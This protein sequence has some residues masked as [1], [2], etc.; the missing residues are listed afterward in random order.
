MGEE[1][2]KRRVEKGRTLGGMVGSGVVSSKEGDSNGMWNALGGGKEKSNGEGHGQETWKGVKLT[3]P[4]DP[5]LAARAAAESGS[6]NFTFTATDDPDEELPPPLTDQQIQQ[7]SSETSQ[8]L[9][10]MSSTLDSALLAEQS[11]LEIASLQTS[12]IT[13]LQTQTESINLLYDDA[14]GSVGE[15]ERANVQLKKAKERGGSARLF[16]L[17][18]LIGSSMALLFLDYYSS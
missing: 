14:I 3:V 4:T 18:F 11:L 17:V 13:H 6:G 8:M 10:S 1:R 5:S 2:W 9:E 15:V 12:L 16:L 7:Y